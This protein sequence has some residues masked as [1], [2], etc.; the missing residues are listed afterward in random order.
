MAQVDDFYNKNQSLFIPYGVTPVMWSTLTL[1][2]KLDI[3]RTGVE[4]PEGT[5]TPVTETTPTPAVTTMPVQPVVRPVQTS[6]VAPLTPSQLPYIP[7][8][9]GPPSAT[10][11]PPEV[12]QPPSPEP[13]SPAMKEAVDSITSKGTFDVYVEGDKVGIY[14]SLDMASKNVLM[15]TKRGDRFEVVANGVS[16]GLRIR[17]SSGSIDVPADIDAKIR[18]MNRDEVVSFVEKAEKET[19]T[20]GGVPWYLI[21]G[22]GAAAAALALR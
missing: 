8:S 11:Y 9:S 18:T 19:G 13:P 2:Q 14:D 22:G 1:E 15:K 16:T 4:I 12:S 5:V 3:I 6:T 10:Y 7:P 17:T 20:G 21:L